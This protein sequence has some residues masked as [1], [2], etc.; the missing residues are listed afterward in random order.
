MTLVDGDTVDTTNRNRQLPALR[1]T[2]GDLKTEV[3][4]ARLRDINPQ[5]QLTLQQVRRV[6]WLWV[7]QLQTPLPHM[8]LSPV[9]TPRNTVQP[10]LCTLPACAV[11]LCAGV[12]GP[13]ARCSAGAAAG[14]RLRNRRD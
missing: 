14:V 11:L 4:A 5:L 13:D 7:R 12:L 1:S 6:V 9:S 8:V 10:T 2:V 3:V